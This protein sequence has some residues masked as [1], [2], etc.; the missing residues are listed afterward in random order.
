[1]LHGSSNP[2]CLLVAARQFPWIGEL[3]SWHARTFNRASDSLFLDAPVDELLSAADIP[4]DSLL[5]T[6]DITVPGARAA[7]A[8][9]AATTP[10]VPNTAT[11][12][13]WQCCHSQMLTIGIC[14]I[15]EEGRRTGSGTR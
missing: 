2:E 14:R 3:T 12:Q 15:R 4:T 7:A 6:V 11:H 9:L 8:G 1:M 5:M 13:V 10:A